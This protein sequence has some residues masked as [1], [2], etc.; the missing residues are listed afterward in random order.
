[1]D[2]GSATVPPN[3][4]TAAAAT[5]DRFEPP[6]KKGRA[7]RRLVRLVLTVALLGALGGAAWWWLQG[8]LVETPGMVGMTVAQA[9]QVAESAGLSVVVG[10]EEYSEAIPVDAIVSTEPGPGDSVAPGQTVTLVLSLGPE[11]YD[12]PSIVGST[13]AEA[14][15]ALAD[16]T[17]V[18]GEVTRRFSE[19]VPKGQVIAQQLAAGVEVKRGADVSF[20]VSKGR[21]PIDVPDVVGESRQTAADE[22]EAAGLVAR[23][24]D[25][26]S[27]EV[28]KGQVIS[29]DPSDGTVFRGDD[30]SVIVSLGPQNVVVPDVE[31]EDAEAAQAEL[32]AAGLV[33]RTI[34]LLPAGPNNVL[35][36]APAEGSTVKSGSEVTIYI[37]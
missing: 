1:V 23:F 24:D 35:R 17:L 14:E 10:G 7:K 19:D 22:I 33:V 26:F 21:Q 37:F 31:G 18:P 28:A 6:P 16:L 2:A 4:V 32:E 25:A 20:V 8:R 12:V 3:P 34:V 36:Q 15:S 29:Q 5:D 11:R 13:R 30:I 9:E 27:D